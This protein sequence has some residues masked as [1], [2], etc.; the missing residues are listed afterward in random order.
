MAGSLAPGEG[1]RFAVNTAEDPRDSTFRPVI[2]ENPRI[3][4]SDQIEGFNRDGLVA[5]VDAFDA[6]EL[7]RHRAY[8]ADLVD[9][10]V[11]APDRRNQYSIINYH[12]ACKGLYE[13]TQA[14]RL[15]D[16]VSDILGPDIV[17]W[18]THLFFKTG[19]DP[20]E[21]PLHQDFMY[22]P[23]VRTGSITAWL[24]LDEVDAG[25]GA[26]TFVPGSHRQRL[27]DHVERSLD[28]SRSLKREIASVEGRE[29]YVNA[30]H[31]GQASLHSDLV[32]HGSAPNASGRPRMGLAIRYAAPDVRPLP[33][34]EWYF[35]ALVECRSSGTVP[36]RGRRPPRSEHP[37]LFAQIWGEFDGVAYDG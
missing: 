7:A 27:L 29:R 31:A 21:V 12:V 33:G 16:A 14:P 34:A 28:G 20:M 8:I 37:E 30:L 17:C 24:A 4:R 35:K 19:Y 26:V 1:E 6:E 5:P 9:A 32:A 15:L 3:L 22:W 2:P 13:I 11:D 18:N 25:N 10:V 36:M 23:L